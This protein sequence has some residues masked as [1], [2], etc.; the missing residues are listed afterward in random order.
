M[1]PMTSSPCAWEGWR[2]SGSLSGAITLTS[3]ADAPCFTWLK[4]SR[5]GEVCSD[6]PGS[7][8]PLDGFM[9][10][11]SILETGAAVF[12]ISL[13]FHA[14]L[15]RWKRPRRDVL[16]LLLIFVIGPALFIFS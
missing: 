2:P 7:N 14:L 1:G 5:P 12:V 16:A 9:N 10:F 4:E 11:E 3:S 8:D 15:W 6:F 13:A